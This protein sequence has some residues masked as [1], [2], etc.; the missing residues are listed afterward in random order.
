MAKRLMPTLN[1]VLVEKVLPPSKTSAGILLP[2]KASKLNSG[3]VV[4][5]G[6]G[7]RD[8]VGN[9][10]PVSVK[11]GDTVLLP[12]YGGTQVNLGD[13]EFHLYR[14]EDILGTLHD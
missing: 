13:K 3:K 7:A 12:E 4:A 11:E 8:R 2:E 9:L 6:P 1:R 14:D 10:I 5:V